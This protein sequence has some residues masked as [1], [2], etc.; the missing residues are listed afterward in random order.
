M[1][2]IAKFILAA[3]FAGISTGA[4]AD[5]NKITPVEQHLISTGVKIIQSFSSASGLRAI[6]ADSGTEKRLFYVT[7][8]GKGLIVGMVF[9][10]D[11][12]NMTNTDMK[13]AGVSDSGNTGEAKVMG[14]AQLQALWDR[15]EKRRWVQEGK[16]GKLIYVFFD[17]NCPYCHRLWQALHAGVQAGKVQVRWLPVALLQETSKGLGAAIYASNNPIDVMGKMVNHQLQPIRVSDRDNRDMA[18]NLL[19]LKDTGYTGVP[20]LMFK[21]GNKIVSMMGS[22]DE[23]E[24]AALLQ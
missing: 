6:V 17:A 21:R 11:G 13:K 19:L 24:L 18:L 7:P 20:A 15:V 23:R 12:N 3:V 5:Q 4:L 14:D 2:K 16:S 1:G 22:P 9:D 10:A 8:D